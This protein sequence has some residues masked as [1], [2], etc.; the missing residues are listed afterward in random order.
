VSES[1]VEQ[2]RDSTGTCA[3]EKGGLFPNPRWSL[4]DALLAQNLGTWSDE[5]CMLTGRTAIILPSPQ[6]RDHELC[7]S[8]VP[9]A[10]VQIDYP[11]YWSA[12][13]RMIELLVEVR[14]FTQLL[15][16][17]SYELLTEITQ[18]VDDIRAKM[19]TGD[20]R[21]DD[22][23]TDQ[24]ASAAYLR[25]HAAF[26][27]GLSHP[28][29]WSRTE[30]VMDKANRLLERMGVPQ[31]L[32]HIQRNI[33]S[34][35]TVVDHVDELYLADLSEQNNDKTTLLSLG[36]AA[37]SLTLTL[38]MLPSFWADSTSVWNESPAA[39]KVVLALLVVA[40]TALAFGLV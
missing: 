37:A 34:I 38:L 8:T 39:G 27:Q 7:V 10:T 21:I 29:V 17:A 18:S 2:G 36:V 15:E 30:Y 31:T 4:V 26:A 3:S 20:I 1:D 40:G 9:S 23:L 25:R 35:N 14:V 19:F 28:Q 33:D 6:W 11:Q 22:R 24:V 12:I 5:F 13:E 16:N 32:Q